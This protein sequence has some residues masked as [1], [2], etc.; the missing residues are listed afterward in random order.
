M[1]SGETEVTGMLG[2]GVGYVNASRPPRLGV[3]PLLPDLLS[4]QSWALGVN[5]GIGPVELRASFTHGNLGVQSNGGVGLRA[6]SLGRW[7]PVV[8]AGLAYANYADTYT[9]KLDTADGDDPATFDETPIPYAY[10]SWTPHARLRMVWQ[11]T[12]EISVPLS[13]RVAYSWTQMIEGPYG[14]RDR[15]YVE[16][17]AGVMWQIPKTCFQVGGGAYM[18]RDTLVYGHVALSCQMNLRRAAEDLENR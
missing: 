16:L 12:S 7:V 17:A 1:A 8:D 11:P 10:N 3:L 15:T 2:L 4:G 5:Q 6:P 14:S 9:P 13:V 18:R